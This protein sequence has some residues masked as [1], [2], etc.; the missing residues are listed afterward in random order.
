MVKRGGIHGV[1]IDT[2]SMDYGQSKEFMAHRVLSEDQIFIMEYLNTKGLESFPMVKPYL[3]ITPLKITGGSGSPARA[4]ILS[5]FPEDKPSVKAADNQLAMKTN[6]VLQREILTCR[7]L[8]STSRL[9][10]G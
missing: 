6:S 2:A 9:I 8:L 5:Q 3:M 1:G 10:F 7:Q 4:I